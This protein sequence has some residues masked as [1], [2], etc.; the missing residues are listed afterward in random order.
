MALQYKISC[1][2]HKEKLGSDV[3]KALPSSRQPLF[4]YLWFELHYWELPIPMLWQ[5]IISSSVNKGDLTFIPE[6]VVDLMKIISNFLL[7][8]EFL[9]FNQIL[10]GKCKECYHWY[11]RVQWRYNMSH[12]LFSK[13]RVF[14]IRRF[15]VFRQVSTHL[16]KPTNG[17]W[18]I[19]SNVCSKWLRFHRSLYEQN[20]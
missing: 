15:I 3:W 16:N 11:N 9:L 6:H 2:K 14:P 7:V 12:W 13:H 19:A 10:N 1:E 18:L 8:I 4:I 17:Y 20:N 5:M